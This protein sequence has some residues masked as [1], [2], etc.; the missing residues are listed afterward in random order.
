MTN[1][2]LASRGFASGVLLIVLGAWGA[3][4]P[5]VGPYFGYAFTPDRAWTY[6]SGRLVLSVLPGALVVLGGLMVLASEGTA[7][8]GGFFAAIG[9]AWFVL[10]APIMAVI[11]HGYGP[12]T[13]VTTGSAVAPS[14]MGLLEH[15]GFYWGLGVLIVFLGALALGKAVIARLI[16]GR[17]RA[18]ATVDTEVREYGQAY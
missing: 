1:R 10:G 9:G 8:I 3:L 15:L 18:P 6:T 13:P 2:P 5:F 17:H 7:A 14:T 12:G 16:G 4:I 11:A